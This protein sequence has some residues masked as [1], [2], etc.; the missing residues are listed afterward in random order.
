[1]S[2]KTPWGKQS[3]RAPRESRDWRNRIVRG[4]HLR[5]NFVEPLQG[6]VQV[7]LDPARRTGDVLA[8]ILGAPALDEAHAY[9]AHLGQF[10]HGLEA[11]VD[12][13]AKQLREFLVVEDLE[14]AARRDLADGRWVEVVVVVAV[15]ALHEY[16]TVTETLGE[17]LPSHVVQMNTWN[18]KSVK[19]L[20][21]QIQK[22]TRWNS[23]V[24][25]RNTECFLSRESLFCDTGGQYT[26]HVQLISFNIPLLMC[27]LVFSMVEFRLT[28]DRRPRQNLSALLDGSVKPSTT[29]LVCEAWKASPT[30]LLSS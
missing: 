4:A 25:C 5:E 28:F 12:G 10:V 1:M 8:V 19:R 7:Q 17:H 6:P 21:M 14:A 20:R 27:R 11:V 30:R 24:S 15:A 29:M 13:L 2:Q 3:R 18:Q 16:A 23:G 26:K 22:E 9:R